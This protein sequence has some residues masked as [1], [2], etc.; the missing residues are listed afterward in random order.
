MCI[1]TSTSIKPTQRCSHA[2]A[3]VELPEQ[4]PQEEVHSDIVYT[5]VDAV[6][7]TRQELPRR[8]AHKTGFL[9]L[10]YAWTHAG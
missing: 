10:N 7:S 9:G 5:A 4:Y 8:Q 3:Y 1:A 6:Y 2:V